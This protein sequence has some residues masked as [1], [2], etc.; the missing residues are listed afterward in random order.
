MDCNLTILHENTVNFK[1]NLSLS[2]KKK[3]HILLVHQ[4]PVFR[5]E[6]KAHEVHIR[7]TGGCK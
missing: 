5:R 3:L 6:R 7:V 1:F 4:F 2:Y